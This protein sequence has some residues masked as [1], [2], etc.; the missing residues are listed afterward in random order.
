MHRSFN[1]DYKYTENSVNRQDLP[2]IDTCEFCKTSVFGGCGLC[3]ERS[4]EAISRCGAHI[5]EI[6]SLPLVAGRDMPLRKVKYY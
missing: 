6:V 1:L 5:D 2:K 4:D 3:D